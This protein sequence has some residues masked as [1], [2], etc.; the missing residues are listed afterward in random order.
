MKTVNTKGQL[1]P[2]PLILTKR[3]L[4]ETAQG[5]SFILII[6]NQV[7]FANV[8]RYLK[9]N[10]IT[11]SVAENNNVW[12]LTVT[13]NNK[14]PIEHKVESYYSNDI[15]HLQKGDFVIS[16]ASDKIGEGDSE[17]GILLMINF[18]KAIRDLD[19]LPSKITFY[20]SGVFLGRK[21]SP[22]Y[23]ELK[24]LEKMGVGLYFCGTCI[25]HYSLT[26]E[27]NTGIVSNM[28][29]IAQILASAGKIIK[30]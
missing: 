18:I 26:D 3:A 19:V 23:D 4:N 22:V 12:T 24:D 10:K 14:T 7:S 27:I 16:I 13:K 5:G 6:D 28:F 21:N 30:L 11:F 25:N 29:E 15:P 20:N 9:D 17:L 2:T 1:C 8:S